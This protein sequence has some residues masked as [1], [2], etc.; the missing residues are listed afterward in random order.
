[1]A[2]PRVVGAAL[3]DDPRAIAP[4][5]P[6]QTVEEQDAEAFRDT[7]GSFGR[8]IRSGFNQLGAMSQAFVGQLSDGMGL[9]EFAKS[10]MAEAEAMANFAESVAPEIRDYRQV[11]DVETLGSFVAGHMG[12]G[13]ATAV[14]AIAGG[15]IGSR[16]GLRGAIAAMGAGSF[17]PNAGEHAMRIKDS[18]GTPGE[19]TAN[20]LVT[21]AAKAALD[22]AGLAVPAARIASPSLR[23]G[24][25]LPAVLKASGAEGLT[26]GGQEV[27]GHLGERALD[28]SARLDKH[29]VI[30]SALAGASAGAAFGAGGRAIEVLPGAIS[31]GV[32]IAQE[33]IGEFKEQ[34]SRAKLEEAVG[35]ED[36]PKLDED[37]AFMRAV[38]SGDFDEK[39]LMDRL[40]GGA[41]E[42]ADYTGK[43][44]TKLRDDPAW[45]KFEGWQDDPELGEKFKAELGRRWNDLKD[46]P[47]VQRAFGAMRKA[48]QAGKDRV[49]GM[50]KSRQ[51]TPVDAEIHDFVSSRLPARATRNL[52]PEERVELVES[53]KRFALHGF[54]ARREEEGPQPGAR[55]RPGVTEGSSD[56]RDH[57]TQPGGALERE[58]DRTT[59][60]EEFPPYMIT[61]LGPDAVD[62]IQG[63]QE[64]LTKADPSGAKPAFTRRDLVQAMVRT[65]GKAKERKT[66]LAS[67]IHSYM[68]DDIYDDAEQRDIATKGLIDLL[69]D[70]SVPYSRVAEAA[71]YMFEDRPGALQEIEAI[72]QGGTA[73]EAA[74][75]DLLESGDTGAVKRGA[76]EYG[77]SEDEAQA[78][79]DRYND[80][81]SQGPALQDELP[82]DMRDDEDFFESKNAAEGP[83]GD[84]RLRAYPSQEEAVRVAR[85]LSDP[86]SEY[87][88]KKVQFDVVPETRVEWDD[89]LG[90]PVERRTGRFVVT[91]RDRE[92]SD[93]IPKWEWD[94]IKEGATNQS[95]FDAGVISVRVKG[96]GSAVKVSVPRLT[97]YAM[98]TAEEAASGET[99]VA[100]QVVRGL[101]MLLSDAN[102]TGLGGKT[103]GETNFENVESWDIPNNTVVA[104]HGGRR[105][106]WGKVKSL[107]RGPTKDELRLER[108]TSDL[109]EAA[110]EAP[111]REVIYKILERAQSNAEAFSEQHAAAVGSTAR[112]AAK[113]RLDEAEKAV[114][115][116]MGELRRRRLE[117]DTPAYDKPSTDFDEKVLEDSSQ[118]TTRDRERVAG[119]AN[120]KRVYDETTQLPLHGPAA[121][122]RGRAMPADEMGI[123]EEELRAPG[124]VTIKGVKKSLQDSQKAGLIK[125]A[126]EMDAKEWW[127][128][129]KRAATSTNAQA[130]RDTLEFLEQRPDTLSDKA[131]ERL[132]ILQDEVDGR[133]HDITMMEKRQ[134][135]PDAAASSMAWG[136]TKDD[137][138]IGM[139]TDMSAAQT[140]LEI[141]DGDAVVNDT[142]GNLRGKQKESPSSKQRLDK[143]MSEAD[144]KWAR[145]H[146]KLVLGPDA[147]LKMLK[148]AD[149][150]SGQ[151]G[152]EDGVEVIR[153]AAGAHVGVLHHETAHGLFARLIK[154]DKRAAAQ[155]LAAASSPQVMTRLRALLKG[156]KAALS[157]IESGAPH[158]AEERLAYMY[159]FWVAGE[160]RVGPKTGGIFESIKRFFRAI[161]GLW[162]ETFNDAA[163]IDK[164]ERVFEMFHSGKLAERNTVAEV[165]RTK[166][167]HR[168]SEVAS[169]AMPGVADFAKRAFFTAVGN[170]H[171]M[172]I[173]AFNEVMDKMY[174]STGAQNM[175]PGL[176]QSTFR[177]R[178]RY[179]TAAFEATEGL[180]APQRRLLVEHLQQGTELSDPAVRAAVPKVRKLLRDLFD[181]M[182]RKGVKAVSWDEAA[183]TYREDEIKF[184]EDYF[185][186]FYDRD[187]ISADRTG[188]E[189]MLRR[190]GVEKPHEVSEKLLHLGR[191]DVNDD[192]S[193]LTYYA[194]NTMSRK[195]DVPAAELA[196]WLV[197]D[198]D[199][200][201]GSYINYAVRRAEYAS[202]FDNQGQA[203]D[204]AIAAARAQGATE[205]Q[206]VQFQSAVSA[207]DGSIGSHISPAMK[208]AFGAMVTYQNVRLL[209]LA[210]FSSLVDVG[211]IA[212]RGGGVGEAFS[213]FVRGVRNL[214]KENKDDA[215]ELAVTAGVISKSLDMHMM[216]DAYGS[217][218]QS[219]LQRKI[220][221]W[222][223]KWNGMESWNRSMRVAATAAA[224]RF[225]I[226]HAT[227]P[228]EH[229]ERY[230]AELNLSKDDVAVVDDKLVLNERVL[231]AL[232]TWVDG[233]VLRPNAAVRPVWMSDPHWMIVSHLKQFPYTFQKTIISRVVHE[234]QNGN[235]TP[236]YALL[237][238]VPM[239]IAADLLRA[240]LTPG[241]A[242]D[243]A[244]D[245]R[246]L[247][248]VV[249]RGVARAGLYGPGE[250]AANVFG[251]L[252]HSKIPLSSL[253]GPQIQ[254]VMDL[255]VAAGRGDVSNDLAR[256]VPGYVLFR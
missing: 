227:N 85:S 163:N 207:L 1:M 123:S 4:I 172:N 194:P 170:V 129:A 105:F 209:P 64:R 228:N 136:V 52:S 229:S 51:R 151:Y 135:T 69:E 66:R 248:E 211:G 240:I 190:N 167:P 137:D 95:G 213:A 84:A 38:E 21:G 152:I 23:A 45:K 44:W 9:T 219:P 130:L 41:K 27:V 158:F 216:A 22:A 37:D 232:N 171:S 218:Y 70:P 31:D 49:E 40:E 220:G 165:L 109:V 103:L 145:E 86:R 6:T 97:G 224:E 87:D 76:V 24:G 83:Y 114:G 212:V 176:L 187:A 68:R 221:Q 10:R 59:L 71:G 48:H 35:H 99:Y 180:D 200:A 72:V 138:V 222:F 58:Q 73:D 120:K 101:G 75:R 89:E 2:D 252:G 178:N 126:E 250:H 169:E 181:E 233:A 53:I 142:V 236:A 199:G 185:P 81:V 98:R 242:D 134:V 17:V 94:N 149:E 107:L 215:Y 47:V 241:S 7:T 153:L 159:Q 79:L 193:G 139:F 43:M 166:M 11:K 245:K 168:P 179:H 106:T 104:V 88:Q 175:E 246:T 74:A 8:G 96:K 235:Y 110:R 25:L 3:G 253:A 20:M 183:Q 113:N 42:V 188:F 189:E 16:F 208:Q 239:M 54:G 46:R 125:R 80:E 119:V 206:V 146:L 254:Q 143:P 57:L 117:G 202:R 19:K 155:L 231:A 249:A 26:E 226:R 196:P 217:Q 127:N 63:V 184:V 56:V 50:R 91:A 141:H 247:G 108:M 122:S 225:I 237:S 157:Q 243:E 92:T 255:G 223:F 13:L 192:L 205:E 140:F 61:L 112:G 118:P 14:P 164:A 148:A 144:K 62:T 214:V 32:D 195:L 28:P 29:D 182:K 256:A 238:Y 162:S 186:R 128:Y 12:S 30:N 124:P 131:E 198:V 39:T 177:V 154:S 93:A 230:L 5:A 234:M 197:K 65:A 133:L 150:H 244:W 251:D 160:L 100:R 34:R 33:K 77:L 55:T 18:P 173:P 147:A 132:S 121:K 15:V 78:V 161:A 67:T 191:A 201:L 82:P 60:P 210:L 102:V 111:N 116:I 203:I 204:R 90:G 174:T 156:D 115:Q 36:P